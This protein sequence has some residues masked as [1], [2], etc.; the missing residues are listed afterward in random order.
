MT[1]IN[2]EL[3][4]YLIIASGYTGRLVDGRHLN[5]DVFALWPTNNGE[6][7]TGSDSEEHNCLMNRTKNCSSTRRQLANRGALF[8]N[9]DHHGEGLTKLAECPDFDE[10]F[11][12]TKNLRASIVFKCGNIDQT[13]EIHRNLLRPNL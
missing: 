11:T 7:D 1:K 5:D 8:V 3:L 13:L 6:E 12:I 10:L 2:L 4:D 9:D